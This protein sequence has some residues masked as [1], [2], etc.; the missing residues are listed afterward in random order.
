M[1]LFGPQEIACSYDILTAVIVPSTKA[2]LELWTLLCGNVV[3]FNVEG[4]FG[5]A[6]IGGILRNS[7]NKSF[8][9]FSKLVGCLDVTTVE[10][11]AIHEI[12]LLFCGSP[13][14]SW[15]IQTIPRAAN[16]TAD[17]LAKSGMYR[18]SPMVWKFADIN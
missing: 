5:K 14:V 16:G 7:C 18:T 9:M 8:I 1:E 6:G 4:D 3:K 12:F 2:G 11:L 17:K 15:S 13:G 10:L